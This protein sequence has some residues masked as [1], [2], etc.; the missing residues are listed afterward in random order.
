MTLVFITYKI[1]IFEKHEQQTVNSIKISI[2]SLDTKVIN[3]GIFTRAFV[4]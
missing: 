4:N 3:K 1:G 2:I